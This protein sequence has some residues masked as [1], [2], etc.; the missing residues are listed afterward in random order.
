MTPRPS[1]EF[2]SYMADKV[3]PS[4]AKTY[5]R[6]E[7]I[8][9]AAGAKSSDPASVIAW[10]NA[11]ATIDK[12]VGSV[13]SYRAAVVHLGKS[14]GLDDV[15]G[16]LVKRKWHQRVLRDA[17]PD[18]GVRAYLA[19][20]RSL[21]APSCDVLAILPFTGLRITEACT[22]RVDQIEAHGS[23]LVARVVGKGEKPRVVPLVGEARPVVARA[24]QAARGPWLFPSPKVIDEPCKPDTVRAHLRSLRDDTLFSLVTPHVLRHTAATAMLKANVDLVKLQ[25]ILG[26]AD[27]STTQRYLHPSVSDIADALGKIKF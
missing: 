14:H 21:P 20:V 19:A 16:R 2:V 11:W 8:W 1:S 27:I 3:S 4:S 7:Q 17:L 23:L 24:V 6:I 5:G 9:T 26:H 10:F 18:E 15:G 13:Q 22:L 25:Q 12:P